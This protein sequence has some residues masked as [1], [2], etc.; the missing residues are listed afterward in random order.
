M[1][2]YREVCEEGTLD[3]SK[4]NGKIVVCLVGVNA[5]VTK[6]YVAAQAGAVG[7]ILAND[8]QS[9]NEIKAD[10]HIIPTSHVTYNDS[11]TISQYISSTRT[12]MAYISSVTAKLGVTPAPTVARFSGRGPSIIEE[13][14]L[15]VSFSQALKRFNSNAC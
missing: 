2:S 13:S 7:M 10:P 1:N 14:I 12:P 6:G 3:S 9:G 4:L 15:K 8:Q 5:R 11:I